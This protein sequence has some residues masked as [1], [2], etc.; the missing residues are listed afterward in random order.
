MAIKRILNLLVVGINE[1]SEILSDLPARIIK[2]G[3]GTE[4]V[5]SL[6]SKKVDAVICKWN[7]PDMPG[8][9][10]IRGLKS[11]RPSVPIICLVDGNEAYEEILARSIG[12]SAVL[13]DDIDDGFFIETVI[14]L[15]GLRMP[16]AS[17]VRFYAAEGK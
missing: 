1:K 2:N 16:N 7:L 12:V 11:I 17:P 14:N 5:G 13:H 9:R 4:A 15:L 6:K 10:F 8:G 3:F